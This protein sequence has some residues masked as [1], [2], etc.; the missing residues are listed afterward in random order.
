MLVTINHNGFHGFN[1]VRVKVNAQPGDTVYLSEFQAAKVT[2]T[3]C[4]IA[5]CRCSEGVSVET[6]LFIREDGVIDI[7]GNYPQG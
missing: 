4:G 7:R 3:A 2:K 1:S 6:P 5:S